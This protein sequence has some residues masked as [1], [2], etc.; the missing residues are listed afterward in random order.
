VFF[1]LLAL[2]VF[3]DTSSVI[4]YILFELPVFLLFS[5]YS[6]F[7]HELFTIL[8]SSQSMLIGH[9]SKLSLVVIIVLNILMYILF[10]LLV[11]LYTTVLT[12]DTPTSDCPLDTS[13]FLDTNDNGESG[14]QHALSVVY[15]IFIVSIA[16]IISLCVLGVEFFLLRVMKGKHHSAGAFKIKL[17]ALSNCVAIAFLGQS[18]FLLVWVLSGATL[19][20]FPEGAI[21]LFLF[22]FIPVVALMLLTTPTRRKHSS[23]SH[24][25]KQTH[26]SSGDRGEQKSSS[27]KDSGGGVVAPS[28][29]TSS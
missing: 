27:G 22:E 24:V 7:L 2:D 23:S 21:I 14:S 20:D 12:S 5:A 3:S 15:R 9:K 16:G 29:S 28:S 26:S 13:T 6:V 4:D 10:V 17:I 8:R 11:V 18:I 19:G 1:L 25:S